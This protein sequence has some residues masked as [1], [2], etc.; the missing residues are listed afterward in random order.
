MS[1]QVAETFRL[2]CLSLITA[3]TESNDL[4]FQNFARLWIDQGFFYLF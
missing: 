2:D 4:S 3:F 1:S